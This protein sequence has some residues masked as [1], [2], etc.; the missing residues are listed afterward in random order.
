MNDHIGGRFHVVDATGRA[1]DIDQ[2]LVGGADGEASDDDIL[3]TAVIQ[4]ATELAQILD[5]GL[6]RG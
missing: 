3:G 4:R 6:A 2:D 1:H 5:R